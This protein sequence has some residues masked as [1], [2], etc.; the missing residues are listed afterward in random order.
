MKKMILI[1]GTIALLGLATS[2]LAANIDGKWVSERS[3]RDGTPMKTYYEFKANG[4]ELTGKIITERQ[5]TPTE[6]P[7]SDGKIEGAN[8]SFTVV[9]SFG[10]N[11]MKQLYKGKLDGDK[12][13]FTME[14]EGG[15]F[16]GMRGGGAGGPGGGGGGA[17]GGPPGGG[18]GGGMGGPPPEIVATRVKE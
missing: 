4:A 2:V 7:I 9:R 5:G 13:T 14:F 8:V 18:A 17:M 15:G 10:G 3:G 16:G 11:E 1:L 12:I 6:T